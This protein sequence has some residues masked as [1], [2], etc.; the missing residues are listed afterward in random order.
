MKKVYEIKNRQFLDA[1]RTFYQVILKEPALI[2]AQEGL[3]FSMLSLGDHEGGRAMYSALI[4]GAEVVPA[5]YRMNYGAACY[6]LGRMEEAVRNFKAFAQSNPKLWKGS[7][8][9]GAALLDARMGVEALASFQQA[10]ALAPEKPFGVLGQLW[11]YRARGNPQAYE[12]LQRQLM[13][14]LGSEDA[15]RILSSK[16]LPV[17]LVEHK[18]SRSGQ[19]NVAPGLIAQ[20]WTG[21]LLRQASWAEKPLLKD[22][23]YREALTVNPA[24]EALLATMYNFYKERNEPVLGG[25]IALNG[26]RMSTN[27][28]WQKTWADVQ[29]FLESKRGAF[30]ALAPDSEAQLRVKRHVVDSLKMGREGN[31][32]AAEIELR[33]VLSGY[34]LL[35]GVLEHLGQAFMAQEDLN[36]ALNLYNLG[37]L[38]YPENK[39]FNLNYGVLLVLTDYPELGLKHLEE[40]LASNPT[41]ET[42]LATLERLKTWVAR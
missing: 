24:N 42:V 36:A 12:G 37:L 2:P 38:F 7:Y 19:S 35:K 26:L 5:S 18:R 8:N 22:L 41:D 10:E 6:H 16:R 27:V 28:V 32:R 25:M 40:L 34:P 33:K 4:G 29:E 11:V 17:F 9:L 21:H 20:L 15:Q 30:E 13:S 14:R 23:F 3:A 31:L 1:A 39:G